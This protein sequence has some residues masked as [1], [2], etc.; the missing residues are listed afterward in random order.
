MVPTHKSSNG[1]IC[2]YCNY[3]T[4][5]KSQY[6][7]HLS[8]SKHKFLQNPTSKKFHT[9]KSYVCNC[10]K[11]YKHSST[12]YS[13]KKTCLFKNNIILYYNAISKIRY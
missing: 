1:F 5:R 7:R 2:E 12:L 10:G 3:S 4:S 11:S 9:E 8:T 6:E 13:H